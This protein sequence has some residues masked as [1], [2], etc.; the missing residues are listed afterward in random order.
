MSTVSCVAVTAR[1]RSPDVRDLRR[2][3]FGG[4]SRVADRA[5]TRACER[6]G[7]I[8]IAYWPDQG[9][10]QI[11]P[12]AAVGWLG[13]RIKSIPSANDCESFLADH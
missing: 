8:Q 12:V 4:P 13:D 11:D 5:L 9:R 7:V 6:G 1:D 3:G 10:Q 2:P